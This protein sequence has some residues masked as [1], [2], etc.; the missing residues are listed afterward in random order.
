MLSL[1]STGK[2]NNWPPLP[3]FFPIKPC[4]YQDFSE[5]IPPECQRVCKMMYYL[6]MCKHITFLGGRT[7]EVWEVKTFQEG[8]KLWIGVKMYPKI[9]S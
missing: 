7:L 2:E 4:F 1:D 9:T 5:E 8:L 3:K 6:W